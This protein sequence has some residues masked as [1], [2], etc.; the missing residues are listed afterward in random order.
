MLPPGHSWP[1]PR[2]RMT[3]PEKNVQDP[4]ERALVARPHRRLY[5]AEF[6][7]IAAALCPQVIHDADGRHRLGCPKA[8]ED[9]A[10]EDGEHG[11]ALEVE[12]A[13]SFRA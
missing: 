2:R 6:L 12:D 5:A 7:K 11:W 9:K 8:L 1:E 3:R 10:V 4:D 13:L